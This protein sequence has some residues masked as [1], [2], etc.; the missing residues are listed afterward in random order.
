MI[1]FVRKMKDYLCR[2]LYRKIVSV[3]VYFASSVLV[4]A[5]R[6]PVFAQI[7]SEIN[8]VKYFDIL[9]PSPSV[10]N[11]GAFSRPDVS[12]SSGTARFNIPITTM[13]VGS[14]EMPVALIYTS[15][16]IKIEQLSSRVGMSFQMEAGGAITR[17]VVGNGEDEQM[18]YLSRPPHNIA[19]DS[20]EFIDFAELAGSAGSPYDT[21]ID[22]FSYSYCGTSGSFFLDS[23]KNPIQIP[24]TNTRI[25]ADFWQTGNWTFRITD[26]QGNQF[27]FGGAGFVEQSK[28]LISCGLAHDTFKPT[29]WFLQ[30]IILY[31]QDSI[32]FHYDPIGYSYFLGASQTMYYA[33]PSQLQNAGYVEQNCP[34]P[35]YSTQNC[36]PIVRTET[37]YLSSITT[38]RGDSITLSYIPR[39]DCNDVLLNAMSSY[40]MGNHIATYSLEYDTYTT[41][42]FLTSV[43]KSSSDNQG[44]IELYNMTYNDPAALPLLTSYA[45]DEWGYFNGKNNVNLVPKPSNP[46]L[47][48]FFPYA[49]ADRSV[50]TVLTQKG[51]LVKIK[52]P[53][54]GYDSIFYESNSIYDTKTFYPATDTLMTG[55]VQGEGTFGTVTDT[56][57]TFTLQFLQ[58]V[59]FTVR[60]TN[61]TGNYPSNPHR[62]EL[63]IYNSSGETVLVL[64]AQP[65][66]TTLSYNENQ[67]ALSLPSGI[68]TVV[69]KAVGDITKGEA[70][71]EFIPGPPIIISK[72]WP[73][74]GVRVA[75]IVTYSAENHAVGKRKFFYNNLGST[76]SSGVILNDQI[77]GNQNN[78]TVE[79]EQYCEMDPEDPIALPNCQGRTCSYETLFSTS[80]TTL[81]NNAANA[82]HYQVVLEAFDESGDQGLIEHKFTV[83]GDNTGELLLGSSILGAT[84]TNSSIFH[85]GREIETSYYKNNNGSFVLQKRTSYHYVDHDE[86]YDE[87]EGYIVERRYGG[88]YAVEDPPNDSEV[89]QYSVT[90]YKLYAPWLV[91]D[92]LVEEEY[93]E[94]GELLTRHTAYSYDTNTLLPLLITKTDS[95]GKLVSTHN[96][97]SG[98]GV[99]IPGISPQQVTFM[100]EMINKNA[101]GQLIYQYKTV[102]SA[103]SGGYRMA[104]DDQHSPS[105][106]ILPKHVTEYFVENEEGESFSVLKYDAAGN[107]LERIKDDG[108]CQSFIWD[109]LNKFPIAEI[110]GAGY[111]HVAATSFEA[112][113]TG[114]WTVIGTC[115][116]IADNASPTGKKHGKFITG[117]SLQKTG[118]SSTVV[119]TVSFWHTSGTN[120]TISGSSD[121]VT[122]EGKDGWFNTNVRI[123]NATSATVSVPP[124]GE[125]DD[126]RIYPEQAVMST[127][128]YE[129]GIGM[130]SASDLNNRITYYMYDSF[131]RLKAVKDYQGNFLKLYDYHYRKP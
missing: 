126:V 70:F 105:G 3:A 19:T 67:S 17:T 87:F 71:I 36:Q 64:G 49:N 119:Y 33:S 15:N 61:M 43:K 63:F 74:A 41:R 79:F 104:V 4:L 78:R 65:G 129:P 95:K 18:D 37:R 111:D 88:C 109:Y 25:E 100:N 48:K 34:C 66:D 131:G 98:M 39:Q 101:I 24:K 120:V 5:I 118:L 69:L 54:G 21:E 50:D 128:T 92:S 2:K 42:N 99:N 82:V 59:D 106:L 122:I 62:S 8:P 125:I 113:G 110:N 80:L 1:A 108:I 16:G 23:A 14:F 117:G 121:P 96:Y 84:P 6:F 30:K 9:P 116:Q 52:F 89:S 123:T 85:H 57:G 114:N 28:K 20:R 7:T 45:Q 44:E 26:S 53:A 73:M 40:S 22:I 13:A 56:L 83:A 97:Y 60:A 47:K 124:N 10:A 90:R 58:V 29:A 68:Y 55:L 112:D 46:V 107:V 27:Y 130:T 115:S 32:N 12:L 72:N 38:S 11:I 86:N 93:T 51:M 103:F 76:Q 102:G 94:S 35:V 91:L 81:Y 75:K 77:F 31:N 127:Y